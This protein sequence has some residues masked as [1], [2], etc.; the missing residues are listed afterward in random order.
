VRAN[1]RFHVAVDYRRM[2][3]NFLD[4]SHLQYV[5]ANT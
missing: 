1:G 5:H 2:I 3:D 4:F